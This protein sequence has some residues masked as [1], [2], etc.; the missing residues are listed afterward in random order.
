MCS[1][2]GKIMKAMGLIRIAND[3]DEVA[4]TASSPTGEREDIDGGSRLG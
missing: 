3:E 2:L 1:P 4:P